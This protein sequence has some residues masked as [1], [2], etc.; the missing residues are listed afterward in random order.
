MIW[1]YSVLKSP[2]DKGRMS[3]NAAFLSHGLKWLNKS[4]EA[5]RYFVP[6]STHAIH[7]RSTAEKRAEWLKFHFHLHCQLCP[8]SLLPLS[9]GLQ[10]IFWNHIC[11]ALICSGTVHSPNT[12]TKQTHCTYYYNRTWYFVLMTILSHL[13]KVSGALIPGHIYICYCKP[14]VPAAAQGLC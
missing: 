7:S 10:D 1:F 5:Q 6:P 4:L 8:V 3:T 14:P 13:D 11:Q 9:Q 12:Q 2:G